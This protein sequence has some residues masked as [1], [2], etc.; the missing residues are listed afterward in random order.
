M[1]KASIFNI[2]RSAGT[3][4]FFRC[5][6]EKMLKTDVF[7]KTLIPR[8]LLKEKN[9]QDRTMW[10]LTSWRFRKCGTY[11]ACEVLNGSYRQSKMEESEKKGPS[12]KIRGVTKKR[13]GHNFEFWGLKLNQRVKNPLFS[14]LIQYGDE[15]FKIVAVSFFF[16]ASFRW[17][18]FLKFDL[19][20]TANN[21]GLKPSKLENY[22]IFGI[23]RTSAFSWYT[24]VR[25][26]GWKTLTKMRFCFS[27]FHQK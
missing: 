10:K 2:V 24:L 18:F 11:W 21:S 7:Q 20:L 5:R 14:A 16:N 25:S 26:Y 19:T 22:N 8:N 27:S 13:H 4:N 1:W 9:I 17:I 23:L 6:H 15:I 12:S 3:W